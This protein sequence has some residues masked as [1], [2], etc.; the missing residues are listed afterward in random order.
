MTH[1]SGALVFYAFPSNATTANTKYTRS[2]L[3]E[4]MVPGDNN[5]NWTFAQGG[6]HEREVGDGRSFKRFKWQIP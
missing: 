6:Y 3:R 2:E 5:T 4:Q 1:T